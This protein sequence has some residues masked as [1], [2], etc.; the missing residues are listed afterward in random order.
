MRFVLRRTGFFLL[1]LWVALTL[2]FALPRLMP[3]NPALAIIGKF[4]SGISPQ[5]GCRKESEN[6]YAAVASLR[7][8]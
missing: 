7:E 8:A 4:K 2:N 6:E 1:T 3:G 5:A